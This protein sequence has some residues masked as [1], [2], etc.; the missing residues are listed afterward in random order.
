MKENKENIENKN[1]SENTG[2]D[3]ETRIEVKAVNFLIFA[4]VVI[5]LFAFSVY[6]LNE[7]AKIKRQKMQKME[8]EIAELRIEI[9]KW[10]SIAE[11]IIR[12]EIEREIEKEEK[13]TPSIKGKINNFSVKELDP[14]KVIKIQEGGVVSMVKN[15]KDDMKEWYKTKE[16]SMREIKRVY[17]G[18]I[19]LA[20]KRHGINPKIITAIIAV[21][22]SGDCL[23]VSRVGARGLMQLMP[24]TAKIMGIK[25]SF[26]PYENVWAGTRYLKRLEKRF[27]NLDTALA[28]YNLGPTKVDE[29]LKH[30]FDPSAYVYAQKVNFVL[31]K[32]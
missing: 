17:G 24:P 8:S 16:K 30:N 13:L 12:K 31:A 19:K 15:S 28:A 10:K 29:L 32:I 22:S 6:V 18:R 27:G 9:Q 25:D 26:H 3:A 7:S 5:L 4:I 2:E 21:E 11:E 23:A 1:D 20:A 14:L